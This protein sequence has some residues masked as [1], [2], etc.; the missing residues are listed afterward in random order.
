MAIKK[1]K[2]TTPTRRY[3][4]VSSFEELTKKKPE[5]TLTVTLKSSGG[6]N[7]QGRITTRHRGGGHKRKYRIIDF[8]RNKDSILAR[9]VSLEYDPNR[10]SRIALLEYEDKEKRYIIAPQGLKVGNE[11]I[12][13]K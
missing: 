13:G 12:S 9:V 7:R 2:P 4:T 6:R 1:H 11:V 8:K 5:K 3:Q 10:S